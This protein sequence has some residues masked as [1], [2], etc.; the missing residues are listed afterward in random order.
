MDDLPHGLKR[1]AVWRN[2]I[3]PTRFE[4]IDVSALNGAADELPSPPGSGWEVRLITFAPNALKAIDDTRQLDEAG[5]LDPE[6]AWGELL[7][8]CVFLDNFVELS[9]VPS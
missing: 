7:E 8:S 6:A 9:L 1:W 5:M 4:A 3:Q 2:A